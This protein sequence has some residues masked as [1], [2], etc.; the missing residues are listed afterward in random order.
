MKLDRVGTPRLEESLR[1][2]HGALDVEGTD[3]LPVLLE[4]RDQ[5]VDGQ[6]NVGDNLVLVHVNVADSDTHAQDLLELELDGGLDFVDLV[7]KIFGVGDGGREFTSLGETWTQKSWDL[8]DQ[9]F[10]SQKG[11]VLLSELLYELLVLVELLQVLDRVVLKVDELGSVDVGGIGENANTHSWSGHVWQ[12]DGT[13]ETFVS[14]GI[15]VFETDLQFNGLH[16]VP[17]LG[18]RSFE[19]FSNGLSHAWHRDFAG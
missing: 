2:A 15:V 6:H 14:L 3:V 19:H 9:S 7:G 16:E 5:E 10:G 13:R 18:L 4:Q 17:L 12:L 1:L 11:I 8:L